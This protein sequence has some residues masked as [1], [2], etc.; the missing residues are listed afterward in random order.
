METMHFHKAQTG[1][2]L[3]QLFFSFGMRDKMP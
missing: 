1:V 3:Q 2:F